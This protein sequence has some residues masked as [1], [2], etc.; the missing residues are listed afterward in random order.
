MGA[1]V[2]YTLVLGV[3]FVSPIRSI[4]C[5]VPLTCDEIHQST[6]LVSGMGSLDLNY[7]WESPN[8][9]PNKDWW[10]WGRRL[11]QRHSH[12]LTQSVR[13]IIICRL[14]TCVRSTILACQAHSL[15]MSLDPQCIAQLHFDFL[16]S[17]FGVNLRYTR[18][19]ATVQS[20]Y[21]SAG[22]PRG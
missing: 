17:R 7:R 10:R 9:A 20:G 6:S 19:S 2:P 3:L 1:D 8:A 4:A 13:L 22:I 18:L 16:V 11:P 12:H 15:R 14:G 5:M 21:G